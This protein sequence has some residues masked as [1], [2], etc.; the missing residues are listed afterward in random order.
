[1]TSGN[2]AIKTIVY[3]LGKRRTRVDCVTGLV[4]TWVT[5][6]IPTSNGVDKW[7]TLEW[8]SFKIRHCKRRGID[9]V[10]TCSPHDE[11]GA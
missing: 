6:L 11:A 4:N 7:S 5:E 1:M 3:V 9:V 2:Q 8:E 10:I